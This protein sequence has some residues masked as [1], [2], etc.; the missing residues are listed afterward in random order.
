MSP[1]TLGQPLR[2][3][4]P[5]HH[6]LQQDHFPRRP[7]SCA[8]APAIRKPSRASASASANRCWASSPARWA[9]ARPSPCAPPRANSI[10][11][12]H[13]VIYVATPDL[14]R[15]RAVRDDRACPGCR[16]ARL[17]KAELIAQTQSLL[18]AEEHERRRRVVLVI[19]EAHLLAPTSSRSHPAADQRRHGLRY[20]HSLVL[21]VGQPTL[22]RQLRMGVFAALDQRIATRYQLS[23]MDLGESA[24]YL[25]HHLALVGR[26]DPLVRRRCHRPAAQ[27]QPGP[28]ARV[29]QRRHRRTHRRSHRRQSAGRRRLR[30][31]SRGR[32]HA[33]LTQPQS[34]KI[35]T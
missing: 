1:C 35:T 4:A 29:Q 12:A 3:G 11:A 25:R 10:Q 24:E 27:G 21:L 20:S 16:A 8:T 31:E 32:T 6:S 7:A 2:L 22:A 9:S 34:P 18:A 26:T 5:G 13:H 23:P 19:D 28:A 30:Q 33:R 15:T 17:Q 14:R